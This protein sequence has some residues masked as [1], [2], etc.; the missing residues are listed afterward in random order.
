M[1]TITKTQ[2]QVAYRTHMTT[3]YNIP[4][5][6][7][8]LSTRNVNKRY[9]EYL[10]VA[11]EKGAHIANHEFLEPMTKTELKVSVDKIY[12]RMFAS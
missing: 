10:K 5:T 12:D 6:A 4:V 9:V 2:F 1:N 8:V 3:D 11:E 7:K